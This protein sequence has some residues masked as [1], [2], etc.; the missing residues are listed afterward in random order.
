MQ[1][2]DDQLLSRLAA[3][4]DAL[5]RDPNA[6]VALQ[7]LTFAGSMQHTVEAYRSIAGVTDPDDAELP[8]LVRGKFAWTNLY[9]MQKVALIRITGYF[10]SGGDERWIVEQAEP[11]HSTEATSDDAAAALALPPG[12]RDAAVASRRLAQL[13]SLACG[14][15]K[16][17][18][19]IWTAILGGMNA[20]VVTK[21]REQAQEIVRVLYTQTNIS[22]YFPVL[23]VRP[24]AGAD[25]TVGN[26]KLAG[27]PCTA[28]V[29]DQPGV[30]AGHLLSSGGS[31]FV[32]LD[33]FMFAQLD[34]HVASKMRVPLHA[35]LFA[36]CRWSTVIF[37]EVHSVMT[38]K[39][40][41]A[42][43]HGIV[44]ATPRDPSG[45]AQNRRFPL[46]YDKLLAVSG[47]LHRNDGDGMDFLRSM[48]PV[49]YRVGSKKL[50]DCGLLSKSA[51]S[52]VLCDDDE[53]HWSHP[54]LERSGEHG[55]SI[56]KMKA[57]ERIVRFHLA[58]GH[59]IM[60]FSEQKKHFGFLERLFPGAIALC[61]DSS[62]T[63]S[64]RDRAFCVFKQPATPGHPLRYVTTKLYEEGADDP[65]L[66]VGIQF[67][68]W[69][70]PAQFKQRVGRTSRNETT[71]CWFYDVVGRHELGRDGWPAAATIG[72]PATALAT[73]RYKL[74]IDDGYGDAIKV[75]GAN[76]L[77]A[78]QRA[79]LHEAGVA[80]DG[81][82][83]EVDVDAVMSLGF[84]DDDVAL[85][86]MVALAW[87][88]ACPSAD[89]AY[90][91]VFFD[92]ASQLRRGGLQKGT[93]E[94]KAAQAVARAQ[95]KQAEKLRKAIG[96]PARG[97]ARKRPLVGATPGASS[98]AGAAASSSAPAEPAPPNAMGVV[99]TTYPVELPLALPPQFQATATKRVKAK[100]GATAV[101][102]VAPPR[103][104]DAV[105]AM[106]AARGR[107]LDAD[108]DD[109]AVWAEVCALRA[110]AWTARRASTTTIMDIAYTVLGVASDLKET[111]EDDGVPTVGDGCGFLHG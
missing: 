60:V 44:A 111:V 2:T 83:I 77:A 43:R 53:Q 90:S 103:L 15:G 105:R 69:E 36:S 47:T 38:A 20:M 13:Q 52:V 4:A 85:D 72:Q 25:G 10:V 56:A 76:A 28:I 11:M 98:A 91:T 82:P 48:G 19:I 8:A 71:H 102:A 106:F 18:V 23:L 70:S 51:I 57:V 66:H 49:T 73:T 62:R 58:F 78:R 24:N 64:E 86:H 29:T 88:G 35:F 7:D 84:D 54:F 30:N 1:K 26:A 65:S 107:P 5:E 27:I 89:A 100:G 22:R 108:A 75:L 109:A 92:T 94:Q 46:M 68:G 9:A 67:A 42:F 93:A 97:A 95:K 87:H 74:L 32:V 96:A 31:G 101:A 17:A 45:T 104:T 14:I 79:Y 40:Q 61:G 3:A 6:R 21:K 63:A 81:V 99:P 33:A 37:D 55:I 50:E 59:K 34:P 41:V 12:A 80:Y 39:A 110:R 16:T